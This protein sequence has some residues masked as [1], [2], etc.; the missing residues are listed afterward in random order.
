MAPTKA[1][2]SERQ[3]DWSRRFSGLGLKVMELTGDTEGSETRAVAGA[4]LVVTT[5]EKWDSITRKWRD[6][7]KLIE[8]VRLFLI[9]EVHIL[10]EDR[11]AILEAVVSRMKSVGT[12]VRF[13]ALSAT[14]PNVEDIAAWLARNGDTSNQP[15]GMKVFGEEFRPVR[16]QK[17]VVG[18]Q[19]NG[20]ND[21][22]FE[23]TCNKRYL[24]RPMLTLYITDSSADFQISLLNLAPPRNRSWSFV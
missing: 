20:N 23:K 3:V 4:D 9:D 19:C 21:W 8:L 14:V 24:V 6:H 1:L 5:P 12:G 18:L 15:A 2:C 22:Q 16:F 10:K 11:G 17:H 13:V 7:A